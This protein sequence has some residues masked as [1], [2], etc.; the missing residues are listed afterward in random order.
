MQTYF[1]PMIVQYINQTS[2]PQ[3]S[4]DEVASLQAHRRLAVSSI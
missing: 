1:V 3:F 2:K 4:F